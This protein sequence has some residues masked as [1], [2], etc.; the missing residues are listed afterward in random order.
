MRPPLRSRNPAPRLLPT[1]AAFLAVSGTA[2]HAE[3]AD[4]SLTSGLTLATPTWGGQL[5]DIDADGDIDV[6]C[7]QHYFTGVIFANDGSGH[8]GPFGIPQII[9]TVGDRHGYLWEE[10]D[11][12]GILDV[13]CSHGGSGGCN[14]S[15]DGNE[16]WK[17]AFGAAF[18]PVADAGG[19]I[20]PNGRGRAFSAADI[21]GDGDL[22]LF[23]VKAPLAGEPNSLYR[24]DGGMSFVDV[25]A[26]WGVADENGPVASL[27]ADVDD[28]GDPDLLMAGDEFDCPTTYHRNDGGIFVDVTGALFGALPVASWADWADLENDGDLDLLLVEGREGVFDTWQ[29]DGTDWWFF[30]NHRFDDDGVDVFSF[31]TPGEDG[32][33]RFR[34][35]GGVVNEFVFLGPDGVHPTASNFPLTDDYVGMPPFTPGVDHGVYCWRESAGGRW[36]VH[37]SAPPGTFG[38]FAG[39]VESATGV[40]GGT[41]SNLEILSYPPA[42]PRVWRN[43]GGRFREL[44][45][46]LAPVAN[47]RA[48]VWVDFDN[49]GDPD[50]HAVNRG[51]VATG[52]EADVLWRNDGAGQFV[53]L[54]GSGWTPGKSAYMADGPVWGDLDRDGDLDAF[55][56]E[57]FG[58]V[59][60][61]TGARADVYRNDGPGGHW[62]TVV[63]EAAPGG[64]TVVGTKVSAWSGG[65]RVTGRRLAN[66]WRGF[67]GPREIHLGL[68]AAATVDSLVVEWPGGARQVFG[69]LP[70]DQ[71]LRFA[72]GEDPTTAAAGGPAAG[73]VVGALRP[74][75]ARGIQRLPWRGDAPVRVRVVDV[76]GCTVRDLGL[77]APGE[78]ARTERWI[79]WDGRDDG[80]A[81]VAGGVYFLRGEGGQPFLVKSV[82]I[83]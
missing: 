49:D 81:P 61:T 7:A 5:V 26:P 72:P 78:A 74:Q 8:F 39:S 16:L 35:N 55:V 70:A 59:W 17:G 21:D 44:S 45:L 13:V 51:T 54:T 52:N 77:F 40:T 47:P 50:I 20:D 65:T 19:M 6:F 27:L 18:L 48:A 24:N 73:A 9:Q 53:P 64:A 68:R 69:P 57:G 75:P 14:C 82:R 3:F 30:A 23:H 66:S 25:A 63:P 33:A 10:F 2:V 62:L 4:V 29:Q 67:Q 37:V 46:G 28:D 56:Q 11:G 22:D 32:L 42:A 41:A 71:L 58:P 60:F 43:D 1:L 34:V 80:G 12:D 79:G 83:R 31:D 15:D 76:R 36:H 38:N